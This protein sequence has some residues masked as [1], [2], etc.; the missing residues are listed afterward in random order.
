MQVKQGCLEVKKPANHHLD[1]SVQNTNS[2]EVIRNIN[3]WN[4]FKHFKIYRLNMMDYKM[5]R[6]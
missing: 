1:K 3:I 5:K 4:I 2:V 6:L